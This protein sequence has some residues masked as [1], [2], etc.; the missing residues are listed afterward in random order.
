MNSLINDGNLIG[1][2][3]L[4]EASGAPMFHNWAKSYGGKPSGI[5]FNLH[6]H[7]TANTSTAGANNN[8]R[9]SLWPGKDSEVER[10]P[11]MTGG[12]LV[13]GSGTTWTGL[14]LNGK[15]GKDS[16]VG[17]Y[18]KGLIMGAGGLATRTSYLPP[19]SFPVA[20]T[21]VGSGFTVGLW[22]NPRSNGY[23]DYFGPL[24]HNRGLAQ[25]HSIITRER[26]NSGFYLGV[27]G[28][29]DN[30]YRYGS[31]D[32]WKTLK[33]F[34][35][36]ADP[37]NKDGLAHITAPILASGWSH[38]TLTNERTSTANQYTAKIFK[39]GVLQDS[40]TYTATSTIALTSS[41]T[42][43]AAAALGIGVSND[44]GSAFNQYKMATGWGHLISGVYF[45]N[46]V[47]SPVEISSMHDAGGIYHL[48]DGVGPKSSTN[49]PITD[50]SIVGY[51]PFNSP[52]YVDAGIHKNPLIADIN[53]GDVSEVLDCPGPFNKG[54]V[55]ISS[56]TA[57]YGLA[58]SS[59]VTSSLVDS[60]SF[61]IAGWFSPEANDSVSLSYPNNILASFGGTDNVY[62]Q[63]FGIRRTLAFLLNVGNE[64]SSSSI[65]CRFYQHGEP[66]NF[67]GV[68]G[69]DRS[70]Y[71]QTAQHVCIM[72]DN[73][74]KG[75]ALYL[76]G[77]LS[78]SGNI[79]RYSETLQL[80]EHMQAV[81]SS[82][83]PILF[84]NGVDDTGTA[85]TGTGQIPDVWTTGGG[86]GSTV[87]D[88]V[89]LNKTINNDEIRGICYNS[90]DI[91]SLYLTLNDPRLMGYWSCTESTINP[92]TIPDKA[93]SF[94]K[95]P[96]NLNLAASDLTWEKTINSDQLSALA[97][98]DI[99]N[100]I[101]STPP[102][103]ASY[104]PLGI[105]SGAWAAG[106]GSYGSYGHSTSATRSQQR[107]SSYA[108]IG[109]RFRPNVEQR[110]VFAPNINNQ[111]I[112]SFDVT[113]SGN[114]PRTDV[115]SLGSITVA[116]DFN[117]N[118]I[119]YCQ[120]YTD[121]NDYRLQAFLT[122]LNDGDPDTLIPNTSGVS[123]V[124]F[125]G[126]NTS[127]TTTPLVSGNI[128]YGIPSKIM[129]HVKNTNPSRMV[130][131][132]IAQIS[133]WI[134]GQLTHS[135]SQA[136][137][138]LRAGT[139][140]I[141]S[142]VAV[143]AGYATIM[144]GGVPVRDNYE[145]STN[146]ESGLGNIYM[147]NIFIMNGNFSG[148]ELSSLATNGIDVTT[149]VVGFTDEQSVQSV[150]IDDPNLL[151]Y[152][153]FN[154]GPAGSGTRDLA[155]KNHLIPLAKTI[156]EAGTIWTGAGNSNNA[157]HNLRFVPAG[158]G[159]AS[160]QT[161]C[162]GITYAGNSFNNAYAV[163]PFVASGADF[164]NL[165]TVFTI[166]FWYCQ[167]STTPAADSIKYIMG[168]GLAP[169]I[170]NQTTNANASWSIVVDD[171]QNIKMIMS[172]DGTMYYDGATNAA[173]AGSVAC[174]IFNNPNEEIN[175]IENF[176]QGT[177]GPGSPSSWNHYTWTYD[178]N[179]AKCYFNGILV[180]YKY[181]G[182]INVPYGAGILEDNT[183]K[184]ISFFVPQ[185]SAWTWKSKNDTNTIN[186]AD[187]DG[188][189]TD[190]FCFDRV[191]SEQEVRYIAY[192]GIA[193]VPKVTVSGIIGGY[194]YGSN[195]GSG[196]TASYITGS[197]LA[198]GIFANYLMGVYDSSGVF[199]GYIT[200][201]ASNQASGIVANY[202][203]GANY[204]S[205]IW[206]GYTYGSSV[207][208]G[209]VAAYTR[210]IDTVSGVFG[211]MTIGGLDA[212]IEFDASYQVIGKGSKSFDSFAHIYKTNSN[213]FD[214]K[215]YIYQDELPPLV[216]I[217]TPY[218]NVSGLSTPFDQYFVGFASGRQ[219]K[220]INQ[221]R[222]YFGDLTTRVTGSVSGY[223]G[224]ATIQ[225]INY[226]V[227]NLYAESHRYAQSG[228]FIA[229][230]EAID[231][232][233]IY[234]SDSII[235]NAA[236]G[237]DPVYITISGVP[238]AGYED[239]TVSF[240]TKVERLPAN[241]SIVTQLVDFGD[242]KTSIINNPTHI[243]LE[244]GEFNPVFIVRDSRGVIWSDSTNNG[245]DYKDIGGGHNIWL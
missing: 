45:F 199:G 211:G 61:T 156:S 240:N 177:F 21:L 192:N 122:T 238:Q 210:G 179:Y 35:H 120:D 104:L 39:D 118:L 26:A 76:N 100:Q 195:L 10:T 245:I 151:G 202:L 146:H 137:N 113:P 200:G 189:L 19:P 123:I 114:I 162:S 141:A 79:T 232:D 124:F 201:Q 11:P 136:V 49:V 14:R 193:D 20:G 71:R 161:T 135:R 228:F 175:N 119:E 129:F 144:V 180:D 111:F 142:T 55:S 190:V 106:G 176:R 168:W 47:L 31:P 109:E 155:N 85:I 105:T 224:Y 17:P 234:S 181:V 24:F 121:A 153:R 166:G 96:C 157:A 78:Q 191:L 68:S 185:T 226:P 90:V 40:A 13:G 25:K 152:W 101:R 139:D 88:L 2:W 194:L 9:M 112:I 165:D 87:H 183:Q 12:Y 172:N 92:F 132:D 4:T 3:P 173:K 148:S 97:R 125:G 233:G 178:G 164:Y 16:Y 93:R 241:T 128:P 204:Y 227:D 222:W 206:G 134:N 230:F 235:I 23:S 138:T 215:A 196:I 62:N 221:T 218:I 213:D 22:V 103:L 8:Q 212:R 98:V 51:Y 203:I 34:A 167:K 187:F 147:K 242:G 126:N 149:G 82:G 174:G 60:G 5:S 117:C 127:A 81:M 29:L 145:L 84:L 83:F 59:G 94:D 205:G 225:G 140:A 143:N 37:A 160:I 72:H 65:R 188:V 1:Y 46:R 209:I 108:A 86:V 95:I 159:N 237:V 7:N 207:A 54:G 171:L 57:P 158:L 43:F 231:S 58:S 75:V 198:S 169:N 229:K 208:S 77:E 243:Y 33:A 52:G 107:L 36:I 214:A 27:S 42:N 80:K 217:L 66:Q 163:S 15:A 216:Q 115:S 6:V 219:G 64:N 244:P 182:A 70:F 74:T 116:R 154:G 69:I 110:S 67:I 99:F 30:D 197:E 186:I 41:N 32:P 73:V 102:E 50:S 38:I 150:L 48:V 56:T 130:T 220:S 63:I 53:Q 131:N 28:F 133:L 184:L 44:D 18:D 91:S 236:S 239:L 223:N 170:V 89:I